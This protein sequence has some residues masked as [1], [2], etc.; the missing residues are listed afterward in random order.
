MRIALPIGSLEA[1]TLSLLAKAGVELVRMK[2]RDY[3][4]MLNH[5]QIRQ[6]LFLRAQ[7]IP[8][9]VEQGTCDLGIV[10]RD[11][12][13]DRGSD[14]VRVARFPYSM[15]GA[16]YYRI[17]LAVPETSSWK[18]AAD[19]PAGSI[20]ATEFPGLAAKYFEKIGVGVRILPSLGATEGKVGMV[21]DACVDGTDTGATFRANR[22]RIIDTVMLSSP[23][24]I[25]NRD[26]YDRFKSP[27]DAFARLLTSVFVP[28]EYGYLDVSGLV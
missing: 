28:R 11:C 10:G 1:A 17:A 16:P 2:E 15:K 24:L 19:L 9:F 3:Q 27:V 13:D 7:E 4:P 26:S 18:Q 23:E 20:V 25:V 6:A 12:V 5:P 14:V 8:T 22:L 21:A